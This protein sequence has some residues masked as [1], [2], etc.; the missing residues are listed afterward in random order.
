MSWS[1]FFPRWSGWL[2]GYGGCLVG[3]WRQEKGT[4][5]KP[6]RRAASVED[7]AADHGEAVVSGRDDDGLALARPDAGKSEHVFRVG[8]EHQIARAG[9]VADGG[10]HLGVRGFRGVLVSGDR[11]ERR[12]GLDQTVAEGE[13]R[14]LGRAA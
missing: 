2:I 12:H 10:D 5:Q 6:A 8:D 1:R 9:I 3:F 14:G 7:D 4:D 11:I 13:A